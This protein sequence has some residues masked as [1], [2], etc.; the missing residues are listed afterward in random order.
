MVYEDFTTYTEVDDD[1]TL[2]VTTNKINSELTRMDALSYVIKDYTADHFGDAFE[3]KFKLSFTAVGVGSGLYLANACVCY[4]NQSVGTMAAMITNNDGF[5][6]VD[7]T[8]I[9]NDYRIKVECWLEDTN[10]YYSI[11]PWSLPEVH[12]IK[13][14]RSTTTLTTRI[15]SDSSFSIL[16]DTITI[17]IDSGKKQYLIGWGSRYS[18]TSGHKDHTRTVDLE[19]LD[20]QEAVAVSHKIPNYFNSDFVP[21]EA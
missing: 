9:G 3:H 8:T 19:I 15:Y 1:A 14:T 17:N 16:E 2:T 13:T 11:K 21:C 6:V 10:D 5:G 20:L 18:T 12:Y 7:Y 4:T